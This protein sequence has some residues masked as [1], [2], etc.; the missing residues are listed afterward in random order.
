[1]A[2]SHGDG[3][4][5]SA[6]SSS[7]QMAGILANTGS[8]MYLRPDHGKDLTK[9]GVW[10]GLATLEKTFVLLVWPNSGHAVP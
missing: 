7:S 6:V 9:N 8:G 5:H 4:V 2:Q 1:M 3:D 10:G